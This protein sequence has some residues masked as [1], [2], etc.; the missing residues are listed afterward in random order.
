MIETYDCCSAE[1]IAES[2]Y[3]RALETEENCVEQRERDDDNI[4]VL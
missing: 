2:I 3:L 4:I 1:R